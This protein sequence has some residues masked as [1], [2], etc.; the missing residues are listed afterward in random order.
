MRWV[1]EGFLAEAVYELHPQNESEPATHLGT[2]L[3]VEN[4]DCKGPGVSKEPENQSVE[5][6]PSEQGQE[7]VRRKVGIE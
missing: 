1:K 4:R 2:R 5:L 3:Q 6:W 7:L